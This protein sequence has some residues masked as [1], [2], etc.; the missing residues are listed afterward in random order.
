MAESVI[1]PSIVDNMPG[2]VTMPSRRIQRPAADV[3]TPQVRARPPTVTRPSAMVKAADKARGMARGPAVV[4]RHGYDRNIRAYQAPSH[5]SPRLA[6]HIAHMALGSLG[7][8]SADPTV[9]LGRKNPQELLDN[10]LGA[11]LSDIERP[12]AARRRAFDVTIAG[13]AMNGVGDVSHGL[14][15]YPLSR[16]KPPTLDPPVVTRDPGAIHPVL[17]SG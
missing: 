8:R 17:L 16:R 5:S 3:V 6:R 7:A 4:W 14:P 12:V 15:F 1:M 9:I 10:M 13:P 2:S 11:L